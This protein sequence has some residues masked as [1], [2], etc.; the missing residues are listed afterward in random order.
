MTTVREIRP[1]ASYC[2]Q[3]F[4]GLTLV[5]THALAG[6]VIPDS[7]GAKNGALYG[8][9]AVLFGKPIEI[10]ISRALKPDIKSSICSKIIS[11]SGS[12]FS[13]TACA[14]AVT[15]AIAKTQD[16]YSYPNALGLSAAAAG[17][18]LAFLSPCI[19]CLI[20]E[21]KQAYRDDTI[22]FIPKDSNNPPPD[23]D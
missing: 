18:C 17:F 12:Y 23:T 1:E 4:T 5:G 10:M 14:W 2:L 7:I 8:T 9:F 16:E 15:N 13:A 11:M 19:Y 20:K 21:T 3:G 6:H 22:A